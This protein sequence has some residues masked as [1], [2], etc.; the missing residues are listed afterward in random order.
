M[1]ALTVPFHQQRQ[2]GSV[3]EERGSLR[4]QQV[5]SKVL[6]QLAVAGRHVL[7]KLQPR[8]ETRSVSCAS[9]ALQC[10]CIRIV[11]VTSPSKDPAD[12]AG[13]IRPASTILTSS[14]AEQLP[15]VA[16]VR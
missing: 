9:G 14:A 1:K 10:A 7:P 11:A 5:E 2:R 16:V 8:S 3:R 13:W 6:L 15:V 12:T 4:R